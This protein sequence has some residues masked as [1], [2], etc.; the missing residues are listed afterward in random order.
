MTAARVSGS[1][2]DSS[3]KNLIHS[4]TLKRIAI[5][6]FFQKNGLISNFKVRLHSSTCDEEENTS[7]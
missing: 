1:T 4:F 3:F 2:T 6:I 7:L 5:Q